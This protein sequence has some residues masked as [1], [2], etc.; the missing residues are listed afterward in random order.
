VAKFKRMSELIGSIEGLQQVDLLGTGLKEEFYFTN[1]HKH[2]F[3]DCE[4]C[5]VFISREVSGTS[6][7]AFVCINSTGNLS[8]PAFD[9]STS[10][11]VGNT[12][13]K[14]AEECKEYNLLQEG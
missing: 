1:T 5:S 7:R 10:I 3:T 6:D 9:Y 4:G 2:A 8:Q 11:E 12:I 14:L 13:L